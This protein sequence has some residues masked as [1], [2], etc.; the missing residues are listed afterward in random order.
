MIDWPQVLANALWISGAALALAAFSYAYW[1]AGTHAQG[2]RVTL[3]QSAFQLLL[4]GAALLV[5]L[6]LGLT[7]NS[8]LEAVIWLAL[9][10]LS[11]AAFISAWRTVRPQTK[12]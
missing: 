10:A 9:A 6:G 11:A 8:P 1:Q 4:R 12:K 2:L 5:C 3:R 7:A